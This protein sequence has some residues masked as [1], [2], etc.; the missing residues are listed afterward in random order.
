MLFYVAEQGV[1]NFIVANPGNGKE[2]MALA[3]A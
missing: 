1:A 2:R 3:V